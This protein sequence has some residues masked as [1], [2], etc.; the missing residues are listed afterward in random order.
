MSAHYE[1]LC[2][3]RTNYLNAKNDYFRYLNSYNKN[4][5]STLLI[6]FNNNNIKK[7]IRL[8]IKFNKLFIN[9]K[10]NTSN[11]LTHSNITTSTNINNNTRNNNSISNTIINNNNNITTHTSSRSSKKIIKSSDTTCNKN[12]NKLTTI[13]KNI[14]TKSC[15]KITT[16]IKSDT[17]E[18][19][20]TK[21][22]SIINNTHKQMKLLNIKGEWCYFKKCIYMLYNS[23][24]SYYA[25]IND[26]KFKPM[27]NRGLQKEIITLLDIYKQNYDSYK[28][29]F[30][31]SLEKK[32]LIKNPEEHPLIKNITKSFIDKSY[33]K[34]FIQEINS[35]I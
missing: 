34:S 2:Y 22:S 3:L 20:N 12:T 28:T 29:L 19:I 25:T 33:A 1:T 8:M 10:K 16:Q 24:T 26:N 7:N 5:W 11:T 27:S 15:D 14:N 30:N 17:I 23:L 6:R 32:T 31:N 13:D 21:I 18:S 4:F 35:K 9:L